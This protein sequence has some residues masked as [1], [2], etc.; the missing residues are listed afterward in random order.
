MHPQQILLRA[1]DPRRAGLEADGW[2]VVARSWA[3]QLTASTA[4]R[5]MLSAFVERARSHGNLRAIIESDIAA[6]LS[7]DKATLADYP[8]GTATQHSPLTASSARLTPQRR[9]FGLFDASGRAIAMTFVDIDRDSAETD[10][11]VVAPSFRR[12]GLGRAV[13]AASVLALLAAG[14]EVFRTGGA[15]ESAAILAA[16]RGLG[17]II[18]EQWITLD[19]PPLVETMR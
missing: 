18:D 16:N 15:A 10:F 5:G 1:E 12:L 6:L 3:A 17:Y 13:K 2:T 4:N 8:G 19:P 14:V 7:L 11:T 9:G